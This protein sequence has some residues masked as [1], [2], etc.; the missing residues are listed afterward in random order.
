MALDYI[1]RGSGVGSMM[2]RDIKSVSDSRKLQ[3]GSLCLFPF[4]VLFVVVNP[5]DS[6]LFASL[7]ACL[8]RTRTR[9]RLELISS[10]YQ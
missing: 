5:K 4:H 10:L 7:R 1:H 8:A 6:R 3:H 9:Y 2:H